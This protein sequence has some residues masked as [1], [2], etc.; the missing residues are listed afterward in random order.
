MPMP[1]SLH[2]LQEI[3]S[4]GGK[5]GA[6]I[7]DLGARADGDGLEVEWGFRTSRGSV[8]SPPELL[9]WIRSGL[10]L[11]DLSSGLFDRHRKRVACSEDESDTINTLRCA[12]GRWLDSNPTLD[13]ESWRELYPHV[14]E[15]WARLE[16][17]VV[18]RRES[19]NWL[20]TEFGLVGEEPERFKDTQEP[21]PTRESQR[22]ALM[23]ILGAASKV[24]D[25][26]NDERSTPLMTLGYPEAGLHSTT[27]HSILALL[28]HSRLQLMFATQFATVLANVPLTSI[29]RVVRV[30]DN[31]RV[32]RVREHQF[33]KD[34]LRKIRY[35]VLNKR[36]DAFFA[37]CW[38]L[39][40]GQTE[41]WL[42][43]Q[44][45]KHLGYSLPLEGIEILEYAQCG[46][47]PLIQLAEVLHI[48]WHVLSDGD[49]A[50]DLY[51]RIAREGAKD[52]ALE[53]RLTQLKEHDIESCLW[54]H[55]Y[56][57]VFV[58]L[59]YKRSAPPAGE[60][61]YAAGKTIRRALDNFAKPAVALEV[62]QCLLSAESPG[63]PEPLES[64]IDNVVALA[65]S[66]ESRASGD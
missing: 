52:V 22:M 53:R 36:N 19:S 31:L 35:H 59:A 29:R 14:E 20:A 64:V 16:S 25:R 26:L 49:P 48:E 18:P 57:S 51:A 55:G 6:L 65:R 54:H 45:A 7:L 5:A 46:L 58:E 8:G 44:I 10:P 21:Y 32:F 62:L 2:S 34:D 3:F 12:H 33:S 56:E 24:M 47:E 40:E 66:T 63:V 60:V 17:R 13:D 28:A 38:F 37:S 30:G 23:L 50:G 43:P 11:I 42:L 61:D 39:V 1:E 27:L 41:A 9:A 4:L 15:L